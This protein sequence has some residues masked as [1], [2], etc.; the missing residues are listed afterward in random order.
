MAD[1]QNYVPCFF[2]NSN[3]PPVR[4]GDFVSYRT[5]SEFDSGVEKIALTGVRE[6]FYPHPDAPE[7]CHLSV[8]VEE[9]IVSYRKPCEEGYAAFYLL[10]QA[11]T[12]AVEIAKVKSVV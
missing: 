10:K 5:K 4:K 2:V 12:N 9:T 8:Y 1:I 6:Y 11:I 3:T 7:Y